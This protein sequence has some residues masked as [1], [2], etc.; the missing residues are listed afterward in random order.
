MDSLSYVLVIQSTWRMHQH[1]KR[2]AAYVKSKAAATLI[3]TSFRRFIA[4]TDFRWFVSDL[5]ICQSTVRRFLATVQVDKL[6][7]TRARLEGGAAILIQKNYRRF[8]AV[9][10]F[11]WI[12]SD[13]IVIQ[14]EV[15][16]LQATRRVNSLRWIRATNAASTRIQAIWRGYSASEV[17]ICTLSDIICS[18]S[19]V[20]RWLARRRCGDLRQTRNGAATLIQTSW[21]R[22]TASM[23]LKIEIADII[24]VQSVC[25]QWSA[26]KKLKAKQQDVAAMQQYVASVK[27]QSVYRAFVGRLN[28]CVSISCAISIQS[29]ARRMIATNRFV[30]DLANIIYCQAIVR[31]FQAIQELARRRDNRKDQVRRIEEA[32]ATKIQACFRGHVAFSDFILKLMSVITIQSL[33]RQRVALETRNYLKHRFASAVKIQSIARGYIA[34]AIADENRRSQALEIAVT[35][36]QVQ[37]SFGCSILSREQSVSNPQSDIIATITLQAW[38]RMVLVS[39]RLAEENAAIVIQTCFRGYVEAMDYAIVQGSTIEIQA[40]VRGHIAR[41]RAARLKQQQVQREKHANSLVR[42]SAATAIQTCFRGYR[43]FVQYVI[44]MYY[45]TKLQAC[46]RG[47]VV[48]NRRKQAALVIERFFISVLKEIEQEVRRIERKKRRSRRRG[49]ASASHCESIAK[50]GPMALKSQQGCP[51]IAPMIRTPPRPRMT[52]YECPRQTPPTHARNYS[53]PRLSP[54]RLQQTTSLNHGPTSN[55]R[56]FSHFQPEHHSRQ[57]YSR[58]SFEGPHPNSQGFQVDSSYSQFGSASGYRSQVHGHMQYPPQY[59]HG[60]RTYDHRNHP[61]VLQCDS[62]YEEHMQMDTNSY[63][64]GGYTPE[65]MPQHA[66]QRNGFTQDCYRPL[67]GA[68]PSHQMHQ[69]SR[70]RSPTPT[71]YANYQQQGPHQ[72]HYQAYGY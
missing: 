21:R 71:S 17:F 4:A 58:P 10:T 28:Y 53:Q 29:A 14:S 41:R 42:N 54:P 8:A 60:E 65:P 26:T 9:N 48:R 40:I 67:Y 25:R 1:R 33:Y 37:S 22:H 2:Y 56:N 35:S 20:R 46:G 39:I 38:W 24:C 31:R 50:R 16:R 51:S 32:A 47:F 30:M 19:A 12:L 11:S 52:A 45:V 63:Q 68:S 49:D 6:R 69:P 66:R 61:G 18:Q 62:L 70:S 3:Q 7:A 43:D 57:E 23:A 59:G 27:I 44:T 36:N 72:R 5:I 34:S 55:G 64:Q 13:V 15:R